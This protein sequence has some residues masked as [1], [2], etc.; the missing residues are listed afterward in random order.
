VDGVEGAPQPV[1]DHRVDELGVA[2]PVPGPGPGQQVRSLGHRLHPAGHH[3][4][5]VAGV[6]HLVGGVEGVDARQAYLVERHGGDGHRDAALGRRLAGGDLALSRLEHLAHDHVVDVV[7]AD[8][9]PFQRRLDGE[10]AELLGREA[11]Q[12]TGLLSDRRT[13]S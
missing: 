12:P 8:P 4:V 5:G 10:P 9:G 7:A 11:G 3:D 1:L 6:D 13:S 2:H